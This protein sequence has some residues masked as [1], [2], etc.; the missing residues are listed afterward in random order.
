MLD[1]VQC[2]NCG[3]FRVADD[4]KT[5][6]IYGDRI[7]FRK[8][9]PSLVLTVITL[10]VGILILRDPPPGEFFGNDFIDLGVMLV[11]FS[12]FVLIGYIYVGLTGG[13]RKVDRLVT[14]HRYTCSLCGYAWEWSPGDPWPKVT[15]RPDLIAKGANRLRKEDQSNREAAH[16]NSWHNPDNPLNNPNNTSTKR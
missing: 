14:E 16:W 11:S 6:P 4:K 13:A 9:I 1:Q 12:G 2:P 7:P 15:V 5:Y 10:V 3:G 8:S